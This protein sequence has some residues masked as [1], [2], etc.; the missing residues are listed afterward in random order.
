MK[1]DLAMLFCASIGAMA[2]SILA[3]YAALRRSFALMRPQSK[4]LPVKVHPQVTRS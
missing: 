3:A 2:F 4:A 1:L